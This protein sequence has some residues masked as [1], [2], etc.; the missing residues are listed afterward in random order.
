MRS[1][2]A[3]YELHAPADLQEAIAMIA[4]SRDVWT[5]IAGGTD[6]MVQYA[7]GTLARRKLIGLWKIPELRRIEL[8]GD[9]L[10]VGAAS[11]FTDLRRNETIRREFPL[12]AQV[13]GWVGG[14]ANQNRATL[15]GNIAN[16][17][18]A[19]DS[20]PALLVYG[21]ELL[22]ASLRGS[23]RIPYREFHTGYKVT[24]LAPDELIHSISLPRRFSGYSS[25]ARKVGTRSA[26][27]IS[28]V[29]IAALARNS[30]GTIE[31]VRIAVGSVA[32][33]PVRL[34]RIERMLE[35]KKPDRT[36]IHS[37]AQAAVAEIQPIDDIRSTA[38]YRA[39]VV[40]NLVS[41]FIEQLAGPAALANRVL[42]RWNALAVDAAESEIVPCCGSKAWAHQMAMARPFAN[43]A[44]LLSS[45]DNIWTSLAEADRDEAL[46]SHPRLGESKPSPS[47]T[48]RSA[49]WSA[50][51]QQHATGADEAAKF[52][53]ADANRQYENKFGRIFILCATG[54]SPAEILEALRRR[55]NNDPGAEFREAAE[56][57]RQITRIR[58]KKW[59]NE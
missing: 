57:Q 56:Q 59:L 4:G 31:D 22:I 48:A 43:E 41:E 3:D 9:E 28:K 13:A 10:R 24:A 12:L 35:G 42:A 21:A 47:A 15:G 54:R 8:A 51:E 11:T 5:P 30:A 55:M 25:Y 40:K 18:P 36:L 6:L 44:A 38:R 49:A 52:H 33:F 32:P 29:C 39:V 19:G 50:Q 37:A 26:Q 45:S 17:S 7:A 1:N 16:A 23:R 58:L 53:L 14:I 20:L 27:A 2:P 46:R 34:A